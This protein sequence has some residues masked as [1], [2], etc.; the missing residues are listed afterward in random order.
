MLQCSL[1][2][3]VEPV[4]WKMHIEFPVADQ[5]I[6]ISSILNQG[7]IRDIPY[8]SSESGDTIVC[9][10][11]DTVEYSFEQQFGI[12]DSTELRHTIGTCTIQNM[13]PVE[14][15]LQIGNDL[16]LRNMDEIKLEETAHVSMSKRNLTLGGLSYIVFDSSSLGI[17]INV[18]NQTTQCDMEDVVIAL[19]D[20]EDVLAVIHLP[21]LTAK[22]TAIITVPVAG[23]KIKSPA[24]LALSASIPCGTVVHSSDKIAISFSFNGLIISEAE[25]E[26]RF[27]DYISS[28]SGVIPLADSLKI[29]HLETENVTVDLN[30]WSPAHIKVRL[31]G[32]FYNSENDNMFQYGQKD[33]RGDVGEKQKYRMSGIFAGDTITALLDSC[34]HSFS[35]PLGEMKL[36][37][38]WDCRHAYSTLGCTFSFQIVH[39]GRKIRFNK[40][41]QLIMKIKPSNFPLKR[42]D[43]FLFK[44]LE[45]SGTTSVNSGLAAPTDEIKR[46][47]KAFSFNSARIKFDL[48]PG[49][50]DGCAIDSLQVLAVMRAGNFTN[51]SVILK[52]TISGI[53][54]GSHHTALMDFTGLFN[55]WPDI[56]TFDVK[57]LL[58][59][60]TGF[61]VVKTNSDFEKL[62]TLFQLRPVLTWKATVPLCWKIKE[63]VQIE[64]E[65]TEISLTE[66]QIENAKKIK[67]SSIKIILDLLNQTNINCR[68]YALGAVKGKEELLMSYP[69][70]LINYQGFENRLDDG[71]FAVTGNDGIMLAPR[72][73]MS[74]NEIIFDTNTIGSLLDD[75]HFVIRWFMSFE[76]GVTDA[77]MSEDF[78][79]IKATGVIEGTG[80]SNSLL[81]L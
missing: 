58:P 19:L 56:L 31:S 75:G 73:G 79:Q 76:P 35:V 36:N 41:D 48:D 66:E 1:P 37:P 52:Q 47:Q 43:G 49:L 64:L 10:R 45:Q 27:I 16:P 50:M 21:H 3:V 53:T 44:K 34:S 62:N 20:H 72:N 81:K 59:P 38:G 80:N 67:N 33:N 60:G 7:P 77:L 32:S 29:D 12:S 2:D 4:E 6:P 61:S 5:K 30:I 17:K 63:T 40:N 24:A 13:E 55:R 14:I 26:D 15:L 74:L 42:I 28:F 57:L 54:S 78:F 69:D 25:I 68:I 18:T 22:E 65:K 11:S 51:D 9:I 46:L 70:S 8:D 23:K 71:L 39:E